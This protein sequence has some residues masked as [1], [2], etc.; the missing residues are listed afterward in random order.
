MIIEF[1]HTNL[2]TLIVK[3]LKPERNHNIM[4]TRW[5]YIHISE[6][7]ILDKDTKNMTIHYVYTYKIGTSLLYLNVMDIHF[8]TCYQRKSYFCK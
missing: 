3:K 8:Y 5:Q 6:Y 4:V 1:G 2:K 7:A